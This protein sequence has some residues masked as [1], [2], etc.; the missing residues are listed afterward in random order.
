MPLGAAGPAAAVDLNSPHDLAALVVPAAASG[1]Q[2]IRRF[3]FIAM[4]GSHQIWALDLDHGICQPF[5]GGGGEG[6]RDGARGEALLAQPSGLALNRRW[7]F[8]A[9]SEASA[10]RCIDLESDEVTTVV[11]EGLFVFG[12]ADGTWDEARLQHPL[13]VAA[14]GATLYVAD[15]YNHKVKAVDLERNTVATVAGDGTPGHE[16]G[17]PG[18]LFEPGGLSAA[19]GDMLLVADTG[20][21]AIRVLDLA[22]GELRTLALEPLG[23]PAHGLHP[24]CPS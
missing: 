2:G 4:S 10:L 8:V 9:D 21:H 13:G 11:G 16:D 15:T 12:D 23:T 5:A 22:R 20:N 19:G 7:L 14:A 6:I 18:R 17:R 3:L 1:G 24:S